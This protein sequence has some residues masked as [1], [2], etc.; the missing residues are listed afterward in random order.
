MQENTDENSDFVLISRAM[1]LSTYCLTY[2]LCLVPWVFLK[3]SLWVTKEM[4]E[5][6]AA[7]EASLSCFNKRDA[8]FL[9]SSTIGLLC[10]FLFWWVK[11]PA[12]VGQTKDISLVCLACKTRGKF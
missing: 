2:F 5:R 3:F 7:P 11:G 4:L 10:E 1:W 8:P 12:K 9:I 6:R